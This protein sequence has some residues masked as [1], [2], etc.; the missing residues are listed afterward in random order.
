MNKTISCIC[1]VKPGLTYFKLLEIFYKKKHKNDF[2]LLNPLKRIDFPT[3]AALDWRK[4]LAFFSNLKGFLKKSMKHILSLLQ[5]LNSFSLFRTYKQ[6]EMVD[7]KYDNY[8]VEIKWHTEVDYYRLS[9][10]LQH[11]VKIIP[12][13]L[14]QY[15]LNWPKHSIMSNCNESR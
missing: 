3:F 2:I 11:W 5:F 9:Y 15:N 8:P 4:Y 12:E 1:C 7:F 13:S 6:E 14:L 10:S